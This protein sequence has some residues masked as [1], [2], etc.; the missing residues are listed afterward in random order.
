MI[1]QCVACGEE[2]EVV[3]VKEKA[4]MRIKGVDFEYEAEYFYCEIEDEYYA[5]EEMLDA[6][7]IVMKDTYREKVGILTSKEI[8]EIREKYKL[9]Q[10]G[11]GLIMGW[12]SATIGR[13]ET[14]QIQDE[15]HNDVLCLVDKDPKWL[16]IKLLSK[17][18][19]F[20]DNKKE[21]TYETYCENIKKFLIP[22]TNTVCP[23]FYAK[24]Y[25]IADYYLNKA[26]MSPKKMQKMVY[27]AYR[28][29]LGELNKKAEGVKIRLFPEAI[30][31]WPH[32]PVVY[33]LYIKYKGYGYNNIS[34]LESVSNISLPKGILDILEDVWE[35][36]GGYTADELEKM[37]HE[38]APWLEAREGLGTSEHSNQ[39][40][41][42]DLIFDCYNESILS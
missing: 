32:G 4:P 42:D 29:V 40:V 16:L 34:K 17:K 13:Y 8:K 36:Y 37:T 21:S 18:Q 23:N 35:E 1:K 38:Q 11:L 41:S 20:I 12:G 7:N 14:Y 22:E 2:H 31:A 39:V 3:I 9:S 15:V 27:Y 25:E 24:A 6:N 30:Q 10:K 5:S 26:A 28:S 33:D 19:V